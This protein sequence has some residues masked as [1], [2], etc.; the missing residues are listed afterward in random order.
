M[1]NESVKKIPHV[2]N[3]PIGDYVDASFNKAC[4][5]ANE[6]SLINEDR[7]NEIFCP[8]RHSAQIIWTKRCGY[9]KYAISNAYAID[10]DLAEVSFSMELCSE[11]HGFNNNYPSDI[12]F[13]INDTELCTWTCPGDFGDR[14][15]KFTPYWW[16][17]ESTKYGLLTTVSVRK[18]GVYLNGELINK[19]V[20][21]SDLKLDSG[22]R[23][24]F[25]IAVKETAEHLGGFNI[26]GEKFGDYNQ[27][28]VFTAITDTNA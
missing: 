2:V 4:G 27:A 11:A 16:F 28:I 12:T 5:M 14:Y 21:I 25:T 20:T 24:T 22:N 19:R 9:L 18:S 10:D 15:G 23:T 8:E 7:P 13:F 1:P 3:I 6:E 17:S 26:F